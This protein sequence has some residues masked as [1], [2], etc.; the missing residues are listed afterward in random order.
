MQPQ[1]YFTILVFFLLA[2]F[3]RFIYPRC[4][5]WFGEKT[6]AIILSTLPQDK[7][8]VINNVM[9]RQT[10]GKTTQIDHVVISPYGIFIIETKNYKGYITGSEWGEKWTENKKYS[11]P[12]PLKQNYGHMKAL[13][14]LLELAEEMFVPIVVFT[15]DATVKIQSERIVYTTQLRKTIRAYQEPKMGAD[16]VNAITDKIKN[17]NIDSKKARKDHVQ[18]IR[19]D[20]LERKHM[21]EQKICPQCGGALV[22]RSGK[23]GAFMGC[24][25]YPKCRFTTDL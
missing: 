9:L 19:Q 21:I 24:S 6:V 23:H 15:V 12:N 7:Y 2:F 5:G 22:C 14:E 10:N 17:T 11:I 4:K 3:L 18:T 25:N 13:A 20:M 16:Q 1:N 8:Q